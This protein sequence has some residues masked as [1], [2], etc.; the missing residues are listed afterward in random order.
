MIALPS[1]LA[2]TAD[3]A[4][5]IVPEDPDNFDPED[6]PH[7]YVFCCVQLG[8]AMKDPAEHFFNAKIIAD[9]TEEQVKAVTLNELISKGLVQ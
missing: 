2:N 5:I 9:L 7:F 3:K 6:Y 8:K 4:G 1:V